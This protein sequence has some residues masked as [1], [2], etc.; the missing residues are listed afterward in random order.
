MS[1]V[2]E[3][4]AGTP[5]SAV[6]EQVPVPVKQF[7][8]ATEALFEPLSLNWKLEAYPVLLVTLQVMED[9][10]LGVPPSHVLLQLSV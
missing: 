8:D 4:A 6:P 9:K 3:F 1:T 7:P 5:V 2:A 10:L